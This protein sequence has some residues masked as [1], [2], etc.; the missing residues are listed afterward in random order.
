MKHE[1]TSMIRIVRGTNTQ[2]HEVLDYIQSNQ[3]HLHPRREN[4][5]S[6][7]SRHVGDHVHYNPTTKSTV[8][9][10]YIII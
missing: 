7:T 4:V 1:I 6:V 8:L 3:I 2:W 9:Y 5:Y 10:L